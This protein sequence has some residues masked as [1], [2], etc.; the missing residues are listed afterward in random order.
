MFETVVIATDGSESAVRA[1]DTGLDLAERFGATVHAVCVLD[2]RDAPPDDEAAR[3]DHRDELKHALTEL[4]GRT[5]RHVETAILSGQPADRI[6]QYA[7][8]VG[9]D[10]VVLGTR[11]RHGP[12][13]FH[14]GSV[15]E[16][17]VW[18]CSVPVLT[19]RQLAEDGPDTGEGSG[20]V[21]P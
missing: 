4:R 5:D 19:V 20:G 12:H 2:A 8:E 14:L 1:E 13:N 21:A 17:V 7:E 9:A 6:Q 18:D 10:V 11:G 3:R 16:D 15:A